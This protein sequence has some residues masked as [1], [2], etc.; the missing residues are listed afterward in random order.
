MHRLASSPGNPDVITIRNAHS[1]GKSDPDTNLR[2]KRHLD[3]FSRFGTTVCQI[4]RSK[5]ISFDKIH[6]PERQTD[7]H[8]GLAARPDR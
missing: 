2:G 5:V 6:C 3:Q 4:T 1:R 7:M 8:T